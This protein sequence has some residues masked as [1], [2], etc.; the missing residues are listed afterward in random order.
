MTP[1]PTLT[2]ASG[3]HA[4]SPPPPPRKRKSDEICT[5][6]TAEA[7]LKTSLD[8]S[9]AR[10]ADLERLSRE[11]RERLKAAKDERALVDGQLEQALRQVEASTK[12]AADRETQR[13]VCGVLSTK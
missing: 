5:L 13:K 11:L 1:H 4:L 12:E 7:T 9:K 2:G 8:E 3:A 10:V 6:E